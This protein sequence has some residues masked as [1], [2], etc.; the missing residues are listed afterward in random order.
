[1]APQKLKKPVEKIRAELLE[2]ADT[3]RIAKAVGMEL[4]AY[5]EMVLDYLQN[6]DK[7]PV[8]KVASDEEL[9]AAGYEAPTPEEVG[10]FFVA[11]A[12][13]ELGIGGPDFT[14]SGF[15]SGPATAGKPSLQGNEGQQQLRADDPE[16]QQ[17][18]L[19][20]MRK[21]GSGRV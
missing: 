15:D 16:K 20:Q 14:R 13:G 2:D 7:Q 4:E 18:L 1:M 12:R 3:R 8:L 17:E 9:R 5:V 19:N 11:G 10:Q 6:P 21:G